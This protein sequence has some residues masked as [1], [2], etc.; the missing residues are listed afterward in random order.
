[1]SNQIAATADAGALAIGALRVPYAGGVRGPATVI[2]K[3]ADATVSPGDGAA[4]PGDVALRGRLEERLFLGA[5]YRHYVRVEGE[6]VMVD[7][8]EPLEPGPVVVRIPA[9]KLQVYPA[10]G[11]RA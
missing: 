10:I 2:F 11:E 8:A 6:T 3:A 7:A 1:V 4:G 9:G 5:V